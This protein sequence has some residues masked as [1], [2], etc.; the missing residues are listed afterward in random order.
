MKYNTY[1]I[2][3]FVPTP[4]M[5]IKCYT[6]HIR[7][8]VHVQISDNHVSIY[9]SYP[10]NTINNVI[11]STV[12][13]KLHIIDTCPWTNMAVKTHIWPIPCLLLPKYRTNVT[14]CIHQ[15]KTICNFNL[16]HY[17]HICARNKYIS[18]M[19][20]ACHLSKLL[21]GNK[22]GSMPIY[23]PYMSSLVSTMWPVVLYTD[24]TALV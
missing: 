14:A 19:S 23:I 7:K 8:L 6:C 21:T 1:Y 10:L 15:K 2:A 4:N 16:P 5:H 22:W 20:N 17:C 3:L 12:I 9:T 18:Q 11:R 13:H 24:D